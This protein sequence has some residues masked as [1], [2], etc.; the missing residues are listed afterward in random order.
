[1]N[2]VLNP[3]RFAEKLIP[4][5][6]TVSRVRGNFTVFFEIDG[7]VG[8]TTGEKYY[9]REEK[10]KIDHVLQSQTNPQ[11][12]TILVTAYTPNLVL[13]DG[14][15]KTDEL[16]FSRFGTTLARPGLIPAVS[17]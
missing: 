9:S 13:N 11:T 6:I 17:T 2:D 4:S 3:D 12:R 14:E 1:M 8:E 10:R 7:Y 15:F 16:Y 5:R